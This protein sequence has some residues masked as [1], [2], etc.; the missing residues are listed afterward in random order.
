MVSVTSFNG[1]TLTGILELSGKSTDEKPVG[2]YEGYRI[3]NG[4][5][6]VE[7]ESMGGI[8]YFCAGFA[9]ISCG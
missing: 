2:S 4:S 6:F 7:M 3:M 5:T 9:G 1:R 8:Y